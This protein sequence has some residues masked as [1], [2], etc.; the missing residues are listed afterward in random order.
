MSNYLGQSPAVTMFNQVSVKTV[1]YDMVY[2]DAAS[3]IEFDSATPVSFNLLNKDLAGNMTLGVKNKGAGILTID[4]FGAQTIDGSTTI[5]L[6]QGESTTIICNGVEWRSF[7]KMNAAG[8]GATGGGSNKIFWEND[9]SV[10]DDYTVSVGKNALSAGPITINNSITVTVP[11]GSVW[12][13]V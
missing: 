12:T 7:G 1:T 8:G 9:Q 11:I 5:T 2:T 3:L 10:T 6:L 13:V 4:P